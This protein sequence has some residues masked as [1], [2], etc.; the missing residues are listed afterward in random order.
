MTVTD[1]R[2]ETE[3]L[4]LVLTN[5]FTAP[6]E[7][8]WQVWADPRLLERWWGPPTYPATVTD[9]D[10]TPGGDIRYF[11]TGPEGA[12]YHGFWRV[13]AVD[14]PHSLEFED[15]FAD[16]GGR[17]NTDMPVSRTRVTLVADDA[18]GTVMTLTSSY[19][20]AEDMDKLLG[21][22]VIEGITLALNQVDALVTA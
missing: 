19:D 21:M 14:A 15:G 3:N 8:V 22:G 10:L 12:K 18:G 4:A 2:K 1:V 11:M 20:S 5:R 6:V 7:R 16:D 9:H 17:P 13:T